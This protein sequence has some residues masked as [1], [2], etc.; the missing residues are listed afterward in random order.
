MATNAWVCFDCRHA[1]SRP[2]YYR[3]GVPCPT[4]GRPCRSIGYKIPVP[5]KRDVKRWR[6]LREQII[7]EAIERRDRRYSLGVRRRHHLE[8]LI[9]KLESRP[10]HPGREKSIRQL[11]RQLVLA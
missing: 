10:H 8:Q 11:R 9:R 7:K 4:C 6:A 5:P 2:P 3:G 1:V